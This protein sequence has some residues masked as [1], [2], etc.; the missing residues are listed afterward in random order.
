MTA[1]D[2]LKAAWS[3]ALRGDMAERDRL[4]ALMKIQ[5]EAETRARAIATVLAS[6]F[7]VDAKGVAYRSVDI[8]AAGN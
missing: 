4:C 1:D 3:A 2:M 5:L 7:M 8:Y 6:D